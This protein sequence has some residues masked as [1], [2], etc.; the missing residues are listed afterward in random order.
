MKCRLS[1]GVIGFPQS[2]AILAVT[3][4]MVLKC[5]GRSVSSAPAASCRGDFTKLLPQQ[6]TL[7]SARHNPS[8]PSVLQAVLLFPLIVSLCLAFGFLALPLPQ[9]DI[10][11]KPFL[12]I[13]LPPLLSLSTS[14]LACSFEDSRSPSPPLQQ[15]DLDLCEKKLPRCEVIKTHTQRSVWVCVCIS[16]YI[17][18]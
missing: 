6:N 9:F 16:I 4:E 5:S 11:L 7:I 1:R 15:E 18:E 17:Y 10:F 2:L 3:F 14:V 13:F 8:P 12:L